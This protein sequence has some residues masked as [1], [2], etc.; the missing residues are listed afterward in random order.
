MNV[1][2]AIYGQGGGDHVF[3]HS[4]PN[5]I[6]SS[7]LRLSLLPDH[8]K[9]G[10]SLDLRLNLSDTKILRDILTEHIARQERGNPA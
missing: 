1:P 7:W 5:S 3:L 6:R 10:A 2:D 4:D 9:I 8:V